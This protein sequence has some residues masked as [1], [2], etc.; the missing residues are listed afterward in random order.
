MPTKKVKGWTVF[1]KNSTQ[2]NFNL[3]FLKGL[4][5]IQ[6]LA[7]ATQIHYHKPH[8]VLTKCELTR[9]CHISTCFGERSGIDRPNL[10][11]KAST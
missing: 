4:N 2:I 7:L 6:C 1:V 8:K 3:K 5:Y 10:E 11:A 9:V